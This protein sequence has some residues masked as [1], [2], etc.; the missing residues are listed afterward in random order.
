MNSFAAE[1]FNGLKIQAKPYIFRP[2]R[3]G[4]ILLGLAQINFLVA[5]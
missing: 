5:Q 3:G 4:L 1:I 2:N